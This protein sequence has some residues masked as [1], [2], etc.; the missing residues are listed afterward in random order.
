[1]NHS[2]KYQLKQ[3]TPTSIFRSNQ[4][5]V[6]NQITLQH[7]VHHLTNYFSVTQDSTNWYIAQYLVTILVRVIVDTDI[8]L[9]FKP[10]S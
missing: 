8:I 3:Y 10:W 4:T 9:M 6:M 5:P 2:L 7:S 1:M